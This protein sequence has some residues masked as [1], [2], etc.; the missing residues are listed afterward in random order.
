MSITLEERYLGC[1]LGLACGDA[2]GTTVEFSPRG[3][4]SPVQDMVGGGPFGLKPGQW[5]DDTA[6]AICL[7]QSMLHCDAFNPVDQMNR[8]VNWWRW[9]YPS[10]TGECFDI[11]MTVQSALS[12]YLVNGDPMAGSA[13]P[14][15]AGNGSMM[16]LAPVVLHYFGEPT[17]VIHYARES[18]RTTHAAL[19]ALDCCEVLALVLM[20]ALQGVDLEA[21]LLALP[22]RSD[23][24]GSVRQL[25]EQSYLTK[26]ADQIHGSGYCVES[27]EAALW[28]I[29]TTTSFKEA[30]LK[31]ANL[32][33][34]ADTT[35]AI[36]GQIAGALYGVQDIPQH[37]IDQ[38]YMVEDLSAMARGLLQ[39]ATTSSGS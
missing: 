36:A 27:L 5:T 1:F 30:V 33:D 22:C 23:L 38:L 11:G 6:M 4:F 2:V 34:D 20:R 3:S 24:C 8:Y 16:R 12:R 29:A 9:G 17:A 32:G 14:R 13:D 25:A 26:C 15:S 31:A 7:V 19:E 10:P 18:S 35:A 37:W 28:C 39:Q 21:G